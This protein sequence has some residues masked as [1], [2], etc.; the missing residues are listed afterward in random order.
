MQGIQPRPRAGRDLQLGLVG[1]HGQ[2]LGPLRPLETPQQARGRLGQRPGRLQ[3]VHHPGP[4]RLPLGR[5]LEPG[6]D[7]GGGPQPVPDGVQADDRLPGPG[8]RASAPLRVLTVGAPLL[9]GRHG[10][11]LR[12]GVD[13]TSP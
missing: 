9:L 10:Q 1:G 4:E 6:D 2:G 7:H 13:L 12:E 11:W 8:P 5:Q 3:T